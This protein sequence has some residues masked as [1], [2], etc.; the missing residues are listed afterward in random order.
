[1]SQKFSAFIFARGGSKGIKDKNIIDLAGK[2]LIYYSINHALSCEKI[3]DVFVSTDNEKI[4]EISKELGAQIINRP[5]ALAEDDSPELDSWK[6]AINEK[7]DTFKDNQPFISL[8]TTSPLRDFKKINTAIDLFCNSNFDLVL[9]VSESIRNPYLNMGELRSNG[10]FE[11]LSSSKNFYRRQ[12]TPKTY[13]ISTNFY[14]GSP[15]YLMECKNI[16]EGKIG[17][18]EITRMEAIDIDE[19]YDLHLAKLLMENPYGK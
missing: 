10:N 17:V 5:P 7:K 12:D 16:M 6:H 13:D 14:V 4:K 8:P 9:G 15:S 3:K 19:R 18:V 2:P 11:V 1:M